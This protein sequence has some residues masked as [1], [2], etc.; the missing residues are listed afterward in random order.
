MGERKKKG[1]VHH[2]EWGGR[3]K[4]FGEEEIQPAEINP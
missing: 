3:M 4:Y 1:K 2:E